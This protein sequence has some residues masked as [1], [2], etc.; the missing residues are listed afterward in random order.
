MQLGIR[1]FVQRSF[2]DGAKSILDVGCGT[3]I[4]VPHILSAY[5]DAQIVIEL[6]FAEEMLA[7][8][9]GLFEGQASPRT[10]PWPAETRSHRRSIDR[11]TGAAD[12]G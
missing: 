3:G 5:P 4:L 9:L 6:N 1:N 7:V 2:L 10:Q 8:R 12:S 11:I